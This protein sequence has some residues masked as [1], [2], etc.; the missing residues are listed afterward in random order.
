MVKQEQLFP[1]YVPRDTS[2]PRDRQR[3]APLPIALRDV[4]AHLAPYRRMVPLAESSLRFR[5]AGTEAIDN[6]RVSNGLEGPKVDDVIL[7]L[8]SRLSSQLPLLELP[9]LIVITCFTLRIK[10]HRGISILKKE[11]IVTQLP[12][13]SCYY[14]KGYKMWIMQI[15]SK[16]LCDVFICFSSCHSSIKLFRFIFY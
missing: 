16:L 11:F 7:S 10:N 5:C 4:P 14:V 15:R 1:F 2:A 3:A 12:Q 8:F 6:W 13:S 9:Y